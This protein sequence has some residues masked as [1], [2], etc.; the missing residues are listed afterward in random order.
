MPKGA[1]ALQASKGMQVSTNSPLF[2]QCSVMPAADIAAH[3]QHL[4]VRHVMRP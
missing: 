1:P 2:M 4:D 3:L